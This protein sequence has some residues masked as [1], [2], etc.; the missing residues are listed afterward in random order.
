MVLPP[1][2]PDSTQIFAR[3]CDLARRLHDLEA[4]A[5]ALVGRAGQG[6]LRSCLEWMR[7][8]PTSDAGDQ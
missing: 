1:E 2:Y 3:R 6:P 5:G 8:G 7:A 4:Q